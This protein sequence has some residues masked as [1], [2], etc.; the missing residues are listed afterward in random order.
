MRADFTLA[1]E[2]AGVIRICQLVE[3]MP[4]GI[5][6]ASAWVRVLSCDEIAREIERSLDILT[7]S[8]RNVS[9]RHRNMR[10]AFAPT[11]ER[12]S[13]V[14]RDVFMKLSVFR[15]G[16]TRQAADRVAG[17]SLQTLSSLADKSLLRMDA[18]ERYDLQGLLRQ[19]GEE[20]LIQSGNVESTR[21][22]H[23][24]YYLSLI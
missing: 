4:L 8:T 5:E 2:Q 21:A 10:A 24:A 17:A 18:N 19:Y 13:E 15:G 7:T 3:G 1:D 9:L 20:R 12:L 6:L 22:A 16:F 23:G 14:E 11:W